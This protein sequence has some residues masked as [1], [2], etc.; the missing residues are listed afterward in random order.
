[1]S[2]EGIERVHQ[3]F[4]VA[5]EIRGQIMRWQKA[6]NGVVVKDNKVLPST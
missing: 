4:T 3:W 2:G 5:G 1:M 6:D